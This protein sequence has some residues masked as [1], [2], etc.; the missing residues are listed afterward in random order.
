MRSLILSLLLLFLSSLLNACNQREISRPGSEDELLH[1]VE[2][3]CDRE[4][5]KVVVV[6]SELAKIKAT[7]NAP[8]SVTDREIIKKLVERIADKND[9]TALAK[10]T[11][12]LQRHT[13][14]ELECIKSSLIPVFEFAFW[15]AVAILAEDRSEENMREMK[16]LKKEL[17]IDGGDG[18]QWSTI[19]DR[20]PM[21]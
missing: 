15:H 12:A 5:I 6:V 10:M 19:V 20:V 14:G 17:G 3:N 4:K 21:P 8:L 16:F 7:K 2:L 9:L 18:Y 11:W 1:G 13:S